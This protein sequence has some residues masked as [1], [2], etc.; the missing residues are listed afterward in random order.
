MNISDSIQGR[1]GPIQY[2]QNN[3][4]VRSNSQTASP[5]TAKTSNQSRLDAL[6]AK[7]QSGEPINLNSLADSMLKKGSFIDVQA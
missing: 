7:M 1:G 4:N 3:Q 5:S 6:K 2:P